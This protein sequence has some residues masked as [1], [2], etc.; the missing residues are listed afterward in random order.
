MVEKE[1]ILNTITGLLNLKCV[2]K[3]TETWRFAEELIDTIEKCWDSQPKEA[4]ADETCEYCGQEGGELITKRIHKK[5]YEDLI[6]D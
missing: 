5:C 6:V 1:T 3:N 2:D 4:K